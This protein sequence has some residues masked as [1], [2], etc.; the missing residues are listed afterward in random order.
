MI[1]RGAIVARS[2]P[3]PPRLR[4]GTREAPD[5]R[6]PRLSSDAPT[7]SLFT[8][9]RNFIPSRRRSRLLRRLTRIL[10]PSFSVHRVGLSST[11]VR[12]RCTCW[13][14]SIVSRLARLEG[15]TCWCS[16]VDPIEGFR[17][18]PPC[19]PDELAD[20][21]EC[22]SVM[23]STSS[24]ML[25]ELN[26]KNWSLSSLFEKNERRRNTLFVTYSECFFFFFIWTFNALF[27][28]TDEEDAIALRN[29][30]EIIKRTVLPYTHAENAGPIISGSGLRFSYEHTCDRHGFS[31]D[32]FTV[33][34]CLYLK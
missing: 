23:V 29:A 11:F 27:K 6:P 21:E 26:F 1:V 13:S 10:S 22:P 30:F 24:R 25:P 2:P 7:D 28:F 8:R 14:Q 18:F 19:Y 3:Q 12:C 17:S 4:R 31:R 32:G 34:R 16:S 5:R 15:A 33:L 9:Y 20:H